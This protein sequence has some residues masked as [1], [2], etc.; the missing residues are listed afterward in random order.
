MSV[1]ER[2]DLPIEGMTCASCAARIER[3]LNKL[4]GVSASVNYATEKA[5]VEYDPAQ[6]DAAGLVA[7]VE[8]AGYSARLPTAEPAPTEEARGDD[9]RRRLVLACR[10]LAAG[11]RDGDDPGPP[12]PLLAVARAPARDAR[13]PLGGLAVPPRGLEEPAACDRDDGHARLARHALGVGLV[14]RRALLPRRRRGRHAHAVRADAVTQRR[15]R[16]DLPRGRVRRD[17]RSCSRAGTS[18]PGR[19]ATPARHC[20]RSAS[21]A[22]RTSRA[23][24]RTAASDWCPSPIC[25]SVTGSSSVPARRSPRTASSS[26]APRRST[27]P[28]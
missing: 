22:R 21:S 25:A 27:A 13:R 14:G 17:R 20:A 19:S 5:V 23:S 10:A 3:R 26:R 1:V 24:T 8:E 7:V 4:D 12:V 11:A 18:R 28:C 9:L 16:P 15:R 2:L 6:A